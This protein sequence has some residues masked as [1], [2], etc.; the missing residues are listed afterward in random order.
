MISSPEVRLTSVEIRSA[1]FDSQTFLLGFD[2]SNPNPFPLPVKAV[3]YNIR[4]GDQQFASG[5]TQGN[6]TVPSNGD[7]AF[8]I[9]VELDLLRTTTGL[10]SF[11]P[12]TG[13]ENLSYE[14]R[15]SFVVD[16]PFTKPL[17]F[18]HTDRIDMLAA[19]L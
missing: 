15:G 9:S 6:F 1:D 13:R 12:G 11:M 14:L 17:T 18:S 3:S 4:L 8:V 19:G 16:I 7:S 5:R 10:K 2:V